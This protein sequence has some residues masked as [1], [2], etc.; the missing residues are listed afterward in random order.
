MDL[1]NIVGEVASIYQHQRSINFNPKL[2]KIKVRR[3]MMVSTLVIKMVF[4]VVKVIA[5]LIIKMMTTRVII[6]MVLI[7][8]L[9]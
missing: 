5:K 2:S 4:L 7:A 9:Q 6:I 3:A 1:A 8:L